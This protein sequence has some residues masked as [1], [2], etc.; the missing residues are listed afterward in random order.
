VSYS[1]CPSV[2]PRNVASPE[3]AQS[4]D[5]G[6]CKWTAPPKVEK[7]AQS[8]SPFSVYI[9]VLVAKHP[10]ANFNAWNL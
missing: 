7:T 10:P 9:S 1:P 8:I 3:E 5:S 6:F 4:S 2:Q